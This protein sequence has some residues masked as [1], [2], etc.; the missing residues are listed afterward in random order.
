MGD[1]WK[2][3]VEIGPWIVPIAVI[4]IVGAARKWWVWGYIYDEMRED[5]DFWRTRALGS[6]GLV[7]ESIE[8]AKVAVEEAT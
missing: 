1:I 5:R 3:L 2:D 8:I 6:Q 4:I 7:E